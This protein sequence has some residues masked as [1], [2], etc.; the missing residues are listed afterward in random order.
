MGDEADENFEEKVRV[1]DYKIWKKNAPFLYDLV[2]THALEWPSLTCEWIPDESG[3]ADPRHKL[4]LGTHTC[5]FQSKEAL[6]EIR[7]DGEPNHLVIATIKL[8]GSEEE[9]EEGPLKQQSIN[10][11]S[12][13][14]DITMKLPHDGEVNR[15][16][17]MPQNRYKVCF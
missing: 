10:Q 15:A 5:A 3:A 8:P 6:F 16:R 2:L 12:A 1:E 4:L 7:H 13:K 17:A 14:I 11:N 9:E